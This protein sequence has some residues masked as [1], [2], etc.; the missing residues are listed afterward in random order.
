MPDRAERLPD[1]SR[2]GARVG[3]GD[4]RSRGVRGPRGD[5][6]A[7]ISRTGGYRQLLVPI[8]GRSS[9]RESNAWL[10]VNALCLLQLLVAVI[11]WVISLDSINLRDADDVGLVS[12][13]PA[14][15]FIS[16]AL[17]VSAFCVSVTQPRLPSKL[18][19]GILAAQVLILYGT[20][21]FVGEAP[22]TS[23]AWA[24]AGI[25]EYISDHGAVDRSLNAFFNWPGFFVL[26]GFVTD[27]SGVGSPLVL[28]RWASIFFNCLYLLPL[29]LIFR[30]LGLSQRQV[31][32]AAW[33]FLSANWIGQ[34]YL[35]S[36]AFGYFMYLVVLAV[37]L[38]LPPY[39][40]GEL[41][42]R[43]RA[44]MRLS[45]PIV[46]AIVIV[47]VALA[48]S[49]QLTPWVLALTIGGLALVGRGSSIALAGIMLTIAAAWVVFFTEPYLVGHFDVVS[50]PFGSVKGNVNANLGARFEGSE[51]H[52]AVL[53]VRVGL[54][55]VVGVLA[56]VGA[57]VLRRAG[58]SIRALAVLGCGPFFLLGLQRYGGELLL[59]AY[60]FALP[61][62]AAG[63]A[64]ALSF[65][66]RLRAPW[67]HE[68]LDTSDASGIR[69]SRH[70]PL[71][72]GAGAFTGRWQ[73]AV[74]STPPLATS[75]SSRPASEIEATSA[76]P[77]A[78]ILR[79]RDL[80]SLAV[81]VTALMFACVAFLIARY[82]NERMD[83]FTDGEVSAVRFIEQRAPSGA[84]VI[85]AYPNGPWSAQR[86]ADLHYVALRRSDVVNG[87]L[88]KLASN[89]RLAPGSS[90]LLLTRSQGAAGELLAGWPDG[91]LE[92]FRRRAL[93]S[94]RFRVAFRDP[95][96][97]VLTVRG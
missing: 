63:A 2:E 76:T 9:R 68:E 18:L 38:A 16:L 71:L 6:A 19:L 22:R 1:G 7:A 91:T 86:Y 56:V 97:V 73:G 33:V 48:P 27:I 30:Q 77:G 37:V 4:V 32:L 21:S 79:F 62:L 45:A 55:L 8:R 75:A 15:F 96:A 90:Y 52:Q 93:K 72:R 10:A 65:H 85:A 29:F 39:K 95:D 34:D 24:Y 54:T 53:R 57:F 44:S 26:L 3:R 42:A 70:P 31:W 43:G 81:L 20:P 82:G 61:A 11:L 87:R 47:S 92:R 84:R 13:L 28:A 5:G 51:G 23:S 40:H 35:S 50:Q 78:R 14:T 74:D 89:M 64:A 94:R 36:Q 49:H 60:L 17:V 46:V 88:D 59:R 83:F 69:A 67:G 66:S 25:A 12:A 41:G 58:I 80:G